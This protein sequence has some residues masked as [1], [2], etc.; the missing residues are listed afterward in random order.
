M[1]KVSD[2]LK[3]LKERS[4]SPLF[5]SFIIS[6]FIINW[7][8]PIGLFFYSIDELKFDGYSSYQDLVQRNVSLKGS[9][10][11]PFLSSILYTFLFPFVRNG[12][13]IFNSWIKAWGNNFSLAVSK[14]SKI[15]VEKYIQLKEIYERRTSLLEEVLSNEGQYLKQ[16]ENEKNKN[17]ELT[18]SYNEDISELQKWRA[19]NESRQLNGEWELRYIESD[20]ERDNIYRVRINNDVMTYLDTPPKHR[21]GETSIRSFS[22]NPGATFLTMTTVY[23]GGNNVRV[24]H[25]YQLDI[26]SDMSILRGVEDDKFKVE[27]KRSRPS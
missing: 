1:D 3:E 14:S 11:Y 24:Y 6:W 25:F 16:Y 9:F 10:F 8:I 18:K 26:L 2:F 15:S 12:I 7:R 23:N 19:F 20:D 21:N 5:S 4:S 13:I 22:R 27:F 17:L